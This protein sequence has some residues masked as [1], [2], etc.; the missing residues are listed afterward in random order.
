MDAAG[1]LLIYTLQEEIR[2][3][4][5]R[6]TPSAADESTDSSDLLRFLREHNV[7]PRSVFTL[8]LQTLNL[9]TVTIDLGLVTVDLLLLLIIGVLVT[10][11]LIAY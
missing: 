11:Q 10:L 7:Q 2:R 8:L 3:R 4:S 9:L 1:G 6:Y 5:D